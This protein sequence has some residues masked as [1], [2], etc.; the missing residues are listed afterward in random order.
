MPFTEAWSTHIDNETRR[1]NANQARIDAL[2]SN[3]LT[4]AQLADVK[5]LCDALH[6]RI[7]AAEA[8]AAA[9]TAR[10]AQLEAI[11]LQEGK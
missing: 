7:K 6:G 2:E 1:L 10:V 4:K 3:G 5:K 8:S 9:L 11:L